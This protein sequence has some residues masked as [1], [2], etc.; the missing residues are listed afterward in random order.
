M[1]NMECGYYAWGG[2]GQGCYSINY[3]L[4]GK[5]I[6]CILLWNIYTYCMSI[7]SNQ[8]AGEKLAFCNYELSGADYVSLECILKQN[9]CVEHLKPSLYSTPLSHY[10]SWSVYLYYY[11]LTF[12]WIV[13]LSTVGMLSH[14]H[15]QE[16]GGYSCWSTIYC[17]YTLGSIKRLMLCPQSLT[18]RCIC[19]EFAILLC[20]F[21]LLLL[22]PI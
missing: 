8:T 11:V 3:T 2:R 19:S 13:Y 15:E 7:N 20:K 1:W 10:Q 6:H 21:L 12:H 9:A 4:E 16:A 17:M 18:S 14:I 5:T 22:H